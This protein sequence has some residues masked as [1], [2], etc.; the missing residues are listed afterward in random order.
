[1]VGPCETLTI[2]NWLG[3]MAISGLVLNEWNSSSSE[4]VGIWIVM[5]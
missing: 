3:S 1:M 2:P 4:R 5:V